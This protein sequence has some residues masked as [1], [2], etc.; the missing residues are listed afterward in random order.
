MTA[1]STL[2]IRL[3]NREKVVATVQ[4]VLHTHSWRQCTLTATAAA[5][6]WYVY[7]PALCQEGMPYPGY[8][9]GIPLKLALVP[10][11]FSASVKVG[12]AALVCEGSIPPVGRL[13]EITQP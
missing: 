2:G 12:D 10:A 9:S 5:M 7:I 11:L 1:Q 3:F 6:R 4:C 13:Q 8:Q